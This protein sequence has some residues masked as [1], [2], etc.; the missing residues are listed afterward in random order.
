ML[1]LLKQ[2]EAYKLDMEVVEKLRGYA[3]EY[4]IA[5][6]FADWCGDSRRAIPVISLLEEEI[7]IEVRTLGGMKKASWGSDK[8]WDVPPSPK[9]VDIFAVTSS[10][11][12]IIFKK[13]GEEVG[14]IRTRPKMTKSVEAEILKIIEDKIANSE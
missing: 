1:V 14:R 9:E 4:V 12:I 10:P 2:R 3:G 11:T 5:A 8:Q 13:S 7:G 6:C